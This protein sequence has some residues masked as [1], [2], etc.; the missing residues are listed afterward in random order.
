MMVEMNQDFPI[1]AE[2]MKKLL[3]PLKGDTPEGRFTKYNHYYTLIREARRDEDET[4]PQGV[5]KRPL[6]KSD[7][8]LVES[9]AIEALSEHTKDLQIAVWLMEAW[10]KRYSV[11]GYIAGLKFVAA[12][13]EKFW[14]NMYPQIEENDREYRLSPIVWMNDK[15]A[16]HFK[17]VAITSPFD[18]TTPSLSYNDWEMANHYDVTLKKARGRTAEIPPSVQ[19]TL[20]QMDSSFK[21][22]H[23]SF[24]QT[25]SEDLKS[26]FEASTAFEKFVYEKCPEAP[27]CLNKVRETIQE[28]L[29][30]SEK[31]IKEG[32]AL[33]EAPTEINEGQPSSGETSEKDP[34]TSSYPDPQFSEKGQ[35]QSREQAYDLLAKAAEYLVRTEPHSPTPYVVARA[36]SWE[37]KN[38]IEILKDA[39]TNQQELER[40]AEVLGVGSLI[41]LFD[42]D[43]KTTRETSDRK[44]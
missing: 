32:K 19:L 8:P 7:W 25:L 6:K 38:F 30:F 44:I 42:E 4:I 24:Y 39:T 12:F 35:I 5:W 1:S 15:M 34:P 11:A 20:D 17:Y 18:K 27:S 2:Q 10:F 40:V 33:Q 43:T 22:T 16:E 29:H 28:I 41:R 37:K 13:S 9:T 3:S 21:K 23:V 36:L 14:D 26:A 31:I